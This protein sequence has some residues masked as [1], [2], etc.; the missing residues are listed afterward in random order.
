MKK[1]YIAIDDNAGGDVTLFYRGVNGD[2]KQKREIFRPFLLE[3][4]DEPN[5]AG[6]LHFNTKKTFSRYMD[7]VGYRK[8]LEREDYWMIPSLNRQYMSMTGTRLFEGMEYDDLTR[9]QLDIEVYSP[10]EANRFPNANKREDYIFMV[11]F[12]WNGEDD[13]LVMDRSLMDRN[14]IPAAEKDLLEQV[15]RRIQRLDPDVIEMHNGLGFDMEYLV[16]RSKLHGISFGIGRNGSEPRGWKS[17]K[18]FAEREFEYMNWNVFGRTII[19]TMFLAADW[20]VHARNLPG[21]GLKPLAIHFGIS[22]ENRTY[23]EGQDIAALWD[24][25]PKMLE[26]YGVSDGPQLIAEYAIDDTRETRGLAERLGMA[27]FYLTKIVP[28]SYQQA[29]LAGSASLIESIIASM[30]LQK[31]HSIPEPDEGIQ[32]MGGYTDIFERGVFRN[33]IYADVASL[34]PAIMLN[35]DVS[36]GAKDPLGYFQK[37]LA[38]LTELRLATKAKAKAELDVNGAS[39]RWFQLKGQE[40]AFKIKLINSYYGLLG[41]RWSPWNNFSEADRVAETGQG[42]LQRIV[43]IVRDEGFTPIECDTD[44]IMFTYSQQIHLTDFDVAKIMGTINDRT[45]D[46]V[47]VELEGVFDSMLSF[48]KKNYALRKD[49]G[50]SI[51][52]KGG[53]FK[54]RSLEP[55]LRR[56]MAEVVELMLNEDIEGIHECHT[57]VLRT[58]MDRGYSIDELAKTTTLHKTWDEYMT[59]GVKIAQYELAEELGVQIGSRVSYYVAGDEHRVSYLTAYKMARLVADYVDGDENLLW[60]VRRLKDV[61]KKFNVFFPKKIFEGIFNSDPTA[62]DQVDLFPS[63]KPKFDHIKVSQTSYRKGRWSKP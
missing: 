24:N 58:I 47:N 14:G 32:T 20:D 27:A 49:A 23:V 26:K 11:S 46:W 48:R 29:H 15:I 17:K 39:K 59:S 10:P 33:V 9:M 30:Y 28:M 1:S 55:F 62:L 31:D 16:T 45:P 7:V 60:Y 63:D 6:D 21:L 38:R 13:L 40:Q 22:D 37:T 54:A 2:L 53:A 52:L 57:S 36:P 51:E 8:E 5:L 35:C 19:D 3:H 61:S 4:T 50:G 12:G 56:Y 25:D 18:K 44:G 34:Y 43:Q 41:F 42:I